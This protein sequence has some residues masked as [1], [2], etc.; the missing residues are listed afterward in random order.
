VRIPHGSRR[1]TALDQL[2]IHRLGKTRTSHRLRPRPTI[3]PVFL[4]KRDSFP[5]DLAH[6]WH[7]RVGV[8]DSQSCFT[9]LRTLIPAHNWTE[10][11]NTIDAL[12]SWEDNSALSP[13]LGS[14]DHP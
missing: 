8:T 14:Q 3:C 9:A 10:G 2:L 4:A 5:K 7:P 13:F 6:H 11:V 1:Q 12:P